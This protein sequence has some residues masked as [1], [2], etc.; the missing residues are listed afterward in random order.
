MDKL[1]YVLLMCAGCGE[2]VGLG[3]NKLLYKVRGR[4]LVRYALD[5]FIGGG[6]DITVVCAAAEAAEFGGIAAEYGAAVCSGGAARAESV[7]RGLLSLRKRGVRD[8]AAV[9]ICD[10]ARPRTPRTLIERCI[11]GVKT[12]G[13]AVAAVPNRDTLGIAA[14]GVL[15][16]SV[17]RGGVWRIQT[18]QGFRFGQIL[19]AYDRVFGKAPNEHMR[20]DFTDDSGV[21]AAAGGTAHIVYG[22]TDNVK[23]TDAE[24]LKRFAAA[25]DGAVRCVPRTGIGADTHRLA[26]G[27]PLIVGGVT[28]PFERGLEGHSDADVLAHAVIDALLSAAG[29]R[30]IGCYF[31]DTDARYKGA[32]G[33]SLL[34]TVRAIIAEAGFVPI[35]IS[36]VIHA[37][38]PAMSPHIEAMRTNL[39]RA[40]GISDKDTGISAKTGEHLGFIGRGE[41]ISV[42]AA[43]TVTAS[44]LCSDIEA[45]PS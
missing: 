16:D 24:D 12:H 20:T 3:Y 27:R 5:A 22:D 31:P 9:L 33:M 37:Q 44:K 43:A 15:T 6:F 8:D 26:A 45:N 13:S 34:R 17:P 19:S 40:L 38:S 1:T 23:I 30:D 10:G 21:F 41:G 39:S 7:Y 11:E 28:I 14:D 18:P 42:T 29:L 25:A 32:D 35:N 2:R 4:E 36:A